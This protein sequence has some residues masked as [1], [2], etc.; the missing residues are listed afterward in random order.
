MKETRWKKQPKMIKDENFF[1]R[2]IKAPFRFHDFDLENVQCINQGQLDKDVTGE[3]QI[4]LYF[5]AFCKNCGAHVQVNRE[6]YV[7]GEPPL[8]KRWFCVH[9][10][11]K[12]KLH[13]EQAQERAAEMMKMTSE[14]YQE[15]DAFL[16]NQMQGQVINDDGQWVNASN[17]RPVL[18]DELKQTNA[19]LQ[20]RLNHIRQHPD[21]RHKNSD[22][23]D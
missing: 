21:I 9:N 10:P 22:E 8:Y 7:V 12:Y 3:P 17:M 16:N 20:A 18:T 6:T 13:L 1:W 2:W 14:Q 11:A 5:V 4:L 23:N 15:L 19:A